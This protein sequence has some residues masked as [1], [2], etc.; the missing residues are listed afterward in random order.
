LGEDSIYVQFI[1]NVIQRK[2]R[3]DNNFHKI[4]WL[5]LRLNALQR[6]EIMSSDI[7]VASSTRKRT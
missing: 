5:V 4:A 6:L 1:K 3:L 2:F 7:R